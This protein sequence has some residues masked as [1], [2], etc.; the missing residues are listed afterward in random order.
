V[1]GRSV[2]EPEISMLPLNLP[3]CRRPKTA[4]VPKKALRKEE[5]FSN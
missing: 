3:L 4:R 5:L 2:V 1:T